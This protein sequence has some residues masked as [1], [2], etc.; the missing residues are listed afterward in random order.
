MWSCPP[1]SFSDH[2]AVEE[3]DANHHIFK[4]KVPVVQCYTHKFDMG[5]EAV[6]I[7]TC[8]K[9]GVEPGTPL[10]TR[11]SWQ[12]N[13]DA[14]RVIDNQFHFTA[15]LSEVQGKN[16]RTCGPNPIVH[17]LDVYLTVC[18]DSFRQDYNH[19][20]HLLSPL[21]T[22]LTVLSVHALRNPRR[23]LESAL[24][25]RSRSSAL[26]LVNVLP[27]AMTLCL[28]TS[29]RANCRRFTSAPNPAI[30]GVF[31]DLAVGAANLRPSTS[32]IGP[33]S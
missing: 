13:R 25:K 22:R 24:I 26:L 32:P 5:A 21:S 10:Y 30:N 17:T 19:F 15:A 14:L 20:T 4:D 11:P 9:M 12:A 29:T 7:K 1:V 6:Y 23:R 3:V 31:P 28:E 8:A 33:T 18:S 2:S 27:S 16:S